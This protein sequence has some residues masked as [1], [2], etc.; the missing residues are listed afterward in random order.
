LALFTFPKLFLIAT[1]R[2]TKQLTAFEKEGDE[3]NG[4][5]TQHQQVVA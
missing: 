4:A 1:F 3:G 5:T 2:N